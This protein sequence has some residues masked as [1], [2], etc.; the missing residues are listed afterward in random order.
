MENNDKAVQ[1]VSIREKAV[2][3]KN[4]E[5]ANAI[6]LVQ[7]NFENGDE[8]GFTIVARKD[9]YEIGDIAYFFQPDYCLS[10]NS[11]FADFI[12]PDG[13]PNKSRLGKQ[14]RIRAIKFNF[15]LDEY[16]NDP[17]YSV[18]IL[19]PQ[20]DVLDFLRSQEN[21]EGS[22]S[23]RLGIFKY[24][25]PEKSGSG[26]AAGDFPSFLYKTDED[27][28]F[29]QKKNVARVVEDGDV[30]VMTVKRDGSSWTSYCK[31][32]NEL[33]G[34]YKLGVCSR[35]LEKKL[36]QKFASD[37]IDPEG[38]IFKKYYSQEL[39]LTG[40][41]NQDK[42]IF[43][44]NEEILSSDFTAVMKEVKDTWVELANKYNIIEKLPDY[45]KEHGIE[46]A[47]R[48]EIIGQGLKGSGN[49]YNPD[50]KLPQQLVL[51]GVDDLSTGAAQRLHY[52]D[53]F[54]LERVATDL[55]I[56][57][58]EI[59]AEF[60]PE[61]FDDIIHRSNMIFAEYEAKGILIEGVVVRTKHNNK[62]SVKSM[63]LGYDAKK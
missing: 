6:E 8:C 42:E 50:A 4:G 5:P 29:N 17:V 40:W 1:K 16:T 20:N 2:L 63:N 49:K 38:N 31:K 28:I 10:E 15:S 48:G 45:C 47:L 12:A 26:M 43:M 52:G 55:G 44:T 9:L 39:K 57:F 13:Q 46:L 53:E 18:G 37:Y 36:E 62:L 54:N 32:F 7:F 34:E 21:H 25:E 23:E 41:Y 22:L 19:M 51:F 27:N 61:S 3:Y 14:N 59:V 56:P 58:T 35:S 33:Q 11:L 60:I 30:V 24:E